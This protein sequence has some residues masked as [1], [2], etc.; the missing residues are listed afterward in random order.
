MICESFTAFTTG[1]ILPFLKLLAGI[2]S[3]AYFLSF[4]GFSDKLEWVIFLTL[5]IGVSH[6]PILGEIFP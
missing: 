6:F 5:I 1:N 4:H 2:Y 3:M